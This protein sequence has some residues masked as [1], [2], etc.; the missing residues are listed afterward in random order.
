VGITSCHNDLRAPH[1][2]QRSGNLFEVTVE[3]RV[4]GKEPA[5][6][7]HQN[8]VAEHAHLSVAICCA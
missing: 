4:S 2:S 8:D 1:Q 5:L 7:H 6:R 3:L